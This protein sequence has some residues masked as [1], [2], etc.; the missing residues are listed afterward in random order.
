MQR[1]YRVRFLV[2]DPDKG[3]ALSSRGA[4]PIAGSLSDPNALDQLCN[5]CD[6]IVH[7][8][9]VVRGASQADFDRVNV[10]GTGSL[11]AVDIWLGP[12]GTLTGTGFV[13]ASSLTV[14]GGTL[15]IADLGG[16]DNLIFDGPGSDF[17]G[18]PGEFV[19]G[20]GET[21]QSFSIIN[22]ANASF[23]GGLTVGAD[24][25]SGSLLVGSGST[26]T[27]EGLNFTGAFTIGDGG[28]GD[29]LIDG[30]SVLLTQADNANTV[31]AF[32]GLG[33]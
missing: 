15:G 19:I 27:S 22:G 10:D 25:G 8:A 21:V 17:T 6:A 32:A 28:V 33:G 23:T 3:R 18:P 7:A 24:F 29:V 9:G 16:I 13:S 2:R 12:N 1:G 26:L 31:S 5:D 4:Q 11:S 20:Q 14:A 30:G